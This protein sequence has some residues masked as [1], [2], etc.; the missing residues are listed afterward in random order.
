M[1]PGF[2]SQRDHEKAFKSI[3]LKAFLCTLLSLNLEQNKGAL[4]TIFRLL[5]APLLILISGLFFPKI[6]SM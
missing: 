6:I 2:E 5:N 3:D 1:G 4:R